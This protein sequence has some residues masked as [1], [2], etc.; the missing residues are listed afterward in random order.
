MSDE[1]DCIEKEVK[2]SDPA[3]MR[4]IIELLGYTQV[5]K[6]NKKRRKCK[7]RNYEICLDDV[8][9]LG[10]FIEIEIFSDEE[11]DLVRKEL[12]DFLQSLGV[13]VS[14]RVVQGYDTMLLHKE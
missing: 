10:F 12:L 7:Y 3:V 6:V 13:D 11:A 4:E 5:V 1:L 2:I 8:G 9:D 14:K